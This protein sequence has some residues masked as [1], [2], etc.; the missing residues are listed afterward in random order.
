MQVGLAVRVEREAAEIGLELGQRAVDIDTRVLGVVAL[1]DRDGR[2]EVAIAGDRPVARIAQPLP[3]LAVFHVLGNPA[4]LLVE[5]DHPV[6]ELRHAHEPARD[7]LVDQRIAAPPAVRI[8]VLVARLAQQPAVL[9]EQPGER[10]VGLEYLQAGDI[11]DRREEPRALVHGDDHRDAGRLA[12][13]LVILTVGGSLVHDPGALIGGDVVVDQD[14]PGVLRAVRI[15]VGVVVPQAVVRHALQVCPEDPPVDRRHG[16]RGRVVAELLRIAADE[17]RRQKVF[18]AQHLVVRYAV[19]VGGSVRAGGDDGVLD[20]RAHCECEVG[21]Q[22]PR[23]RGPGESAHGGEVQRLRLGPG[24]RE[25]DGDR[26]VLTHLVDIVV[27]PELMVGQRR[28]VAPAVREDPV[29]LVGEPLLVELLERPDHRLHVGHVERLVVVVEVDPAGLARD[30]LLP[31]ARVVQH[32]VASGGV[33]RRDAHLLDLALV[34]DAELPLRLELGRETVRVPAEAAFHLLAAHRLEAREDV[35]GVAGQQMTVVRK[36]VGEGGTVVEDPLRRIR[37]PVDG[38]AE[39]AVLVP[40]R[41]HLGLDLRKARARGD[42]RGLGVVRGL[43]VRHLTPGRSIVCTRTPDPDAPDAVPPRLPHRPPMG[44]RPLFKGCDGP[45][46]F[47]ST[48]RPSQAAVLPK[49]RR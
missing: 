30:V 21:R 15:G 10:L 34:G 17:L 31:L 19:R 29:P 12:D 8:G 9:T 43:G 37:A 25:R 42:P 6:A 45:D 11:L 3:E 23:R 49:A 48:E 7:G 44:M 38:G 39:G 14:A 32:G 41:E 27:H 33:E 46:P 22:C 13:A 2:T 5:L 20:L 28:L 40:E 24:Q 4:D 47:G 26:L 16:V 18:A 1:P 35:L 36:P